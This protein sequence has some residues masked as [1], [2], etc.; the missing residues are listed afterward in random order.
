MPGMKTFEE[1]YLECQRKLEE[2][3]NF[4][5][6][7]VTSRYDFRIPLMLHPSEPIREPHLWTI[8]R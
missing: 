6:P 8:K 4:K 1:A 5:G 3:K 2:F 7:I